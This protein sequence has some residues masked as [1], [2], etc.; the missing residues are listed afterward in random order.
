MADEG[1]VSAAEPRRPDAG[2]PLVVACFEPADLRPEVNPLTG[3]VRTD[4]R[5]AGLSAADEAALEFA[6]RAGDVWGG[7]VLAV[8]AGPASAEA[9]L[10]QA[11]ALGARVLRVPY[12][13]AGSEGPEPISPEDLAG[14]PAAVARLLAGGIEQVGPPAL[15]VCGDRSTSRGIGAVPALLA[16]HLR[17]AQALG[18]VDLSVDEGSLTVRA[19]RR[20]D[21]GWRER[22]RL[23]AP[24][25]CSVEAAGVR[26][27][28]ATLAG[29]LRS[30]DE[31]IPLAAPTATSPTAVERLHI[32]AP[33]PY[34][35]RTKAVPAPGGGTRE[36]LLALTGALTS[37]DPPRLIGP[38]GPEE[39]ADELLSYLAAHGYVPSGQ[40]EP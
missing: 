32:G 35:P 23:G 33:R 9:A 25:V 37:D 4:R 26:L 1:K 36:R 17:A 40:I 20:L 30:G 15:V 34:R 18:L 24:A 12:G 8:A 13:S 2:S 38:V 10:R 29:A 27:R 7:P 28:R 6:L 3:E 16:H 39:G 22:L 5:R 31:P 21:G 14:A 11:R 19:E